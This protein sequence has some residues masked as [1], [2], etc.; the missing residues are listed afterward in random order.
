MIINGKAMWAKVGLK[1]KDYDDYKGK[2]SYQVDVYP[3]AADLE[4]Y[5]SDIHKMYKELA[6]E[7][8]YEIK[9]KELKL[10]NEPSSICV[11][12][13]KDGKE[14]IRFSTYVMKKDRKTGSEYESKV[15]VFSHDGAVFKGESIGNGSTIQVNY[16]PTLW[17]QNPMPGVANAGMKAYLNAILVKDLVTFGGGSAES[18]GFDVETP[19]DEFF[20]EEEVP[21]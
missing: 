8:H 20:K 21:I 2:L 10:P 4:K 6:A 14:Y 13:D 5:K 9:G 12:T 15:P 3:A 17:K 16:T 7:E 1:E 11:G 19:S 18:F